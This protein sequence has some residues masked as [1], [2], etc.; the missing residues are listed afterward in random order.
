MTV[1]ARTGSAYPD[2]YKPICEGREKRAL[3]DALGLSIYGVNHV[4]L[5]PGAASAARHWHTKQDEFI[6]VLDGELTLVTDAGSQI[7]TPG[8]AAGFPAGVPDGHQLVNKTD[9]P[10]VYLEVGDRTAGD[11]A[12]YPD[13]DLALRLTPDGRGFFHKDGK[14]Y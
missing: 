4:T 10:A 8:M 1:A 5:Q 3:G 12:D 11:E 14:P 2:R 9:R 6:Y 13:I 7:L